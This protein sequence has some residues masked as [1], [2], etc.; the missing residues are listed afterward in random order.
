MKIPHYLLA[1]ALCLG[2]AIGACNDGP[3]NV[4]D[5]AE[6]SVQENTAVAKKESQVDICHW[7]ADGIATQEQ[8][9]GVDDPGA[10][11]HLSVNNNAWGDKGKQNPNGKDTGHNGHELDEWYCDPDGNT[12]GAGDCTP[13]DD[14]EGDGRDAIF[15]PEDSDGDG[16]A[17]ELDNCPDTSNPDQADTD[18]DGV[19]DACDNCPLAANP[20]QEDAD[21]DGVGDAC[22]NCVDVP[23]ADQ[24]DADSDGIGDLCDT[25]NDVDEDGYGDNAFGLDTCDLDCDDTDPDVNPGATEVCNGVD[26]DCEGG[27]DE[28]DVCS[29]ACA[30]PLT[31][32]DGFVAGCGAGKSCE[33]TSP[34]N[35]SF[36]FTDIDTRE[37]VCAGDWL[38]SHA[39]AIDCDEGTDCASGVCLGRTCCD[40]PGVGLPGTCLPT[41]YECDTPAAPGAIELVPRLFKGQGLSAGGQS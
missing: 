23:N 14:D 38:C 15:C 6:L 24:A 5:E 41:G 18:E 7:D 20:G 19:G 40:E 22:D 26:D 9:D 17:D 1:S 34:L 31:C 30:S 13:E 10:W 2:I 8:Y 33:V 27:I 21:T 11:F 29:S 3:T 39:E 35:A 28:D 36:C 37:G 32:S 25:C 12:D 16:I 4:A